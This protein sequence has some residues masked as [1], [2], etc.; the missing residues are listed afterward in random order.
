MNNVIDTNDRFNNPNSAYL[1]NGTSSNIIIPY[2]SI[3]NFAPTDS[4]S[5]SLWFNTSDTT[6]VQALFVKSPSGYYTTSQWCYGLYLLG[7][8][9]MTGYANSNFLISKTSINRNKWYLFTVT[10]KDANWKM[11]LNCEL[12]AAD[13]SGDYKILQD[14]YSAIGVGEKGQASG[15]FAV[16]KIDDIRLYNRILRSNEVN[17]L[18]NNFNLDCCSDIIPP[19]ISIQ[20]GS[21][22]CSGGISTLTSSFSSGNIWTNGSTLTSILVSQPGTYGVKE[23]N[24]QGCQS[25][26][27]YVNI[28]NSQQVPDSFSLGNEIATCKNVTTI[29]G[30]IGSWKY[31]WQLPDGS[32]FN[33]NP[34]VTD[35]KGKFVLTIGGESCGGIAKD[36]IKVVA[37]PSTEISIQ[38]GV[39]G[40]VITDSILYAFFPMELSLFEKN[41]YVINEWKVNNT[42]ILGN[43]F[44]V[45]GPGIYNLEW[46]GTQFDSCISYGKLKIEV[47]EIVLPNVITP[48]HDGK[49]DVFYIIGINPEF[50]SLSLAVNSRWGESIFQ[51]DKYENNWSGGN[52]PDGMYF[53]DLNLYQGVQIFNKKGWVQILR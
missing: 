16:G 4:F 35:L 21:I 51:T 23:V 28:N 2:N 19:N 39:Q 36:S 5:I 30:P 7:N 31:N 15:D 13:S 26:F 41:N 38:I 1:F 44:N 22:L 34:L 48:N 8:K 42:V 49:N 43:K 20:G 27:T 9:A 6:K 18:Y 52:A 3:F 12:V 37:I 32:I 33:G 24:G 53:Y 29:T 11:Y 47:R 10:Y 40:S 25:S 14:S 17:Y 46:Q 45:N 50:Q